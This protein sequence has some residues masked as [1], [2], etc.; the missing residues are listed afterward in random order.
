[1]N[2]GSTGSR[3][4]IFGGTFDPIHHAHLVVARTA[5]D[6]FAHDRVLFVPAS[7]PPHKW[8]A[9]SASYEDRYRMV[10]LACAADPRFVPSRIEEADAKS[11]S[12]Q[13]IE[14]IKAN[15]QPG[16]E[17]YFLIGADA[18]S[19][20]A[21]WHRYGD[22]IR[23]VQFIVVTRPGHRYVVPEAARIHKLDTVDLPVSSSAI[24]EML[25]E[26]RLPAQLPLPVAQYINDKG[27]YGYRPRH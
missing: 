16:D 15:L 9:T 26:G 22:V 8:G 23:A 18:F 12:I 20:I 5:A 7:Q 10:E 2:S 14:K 24:R 19:E 21:T 13:T 17:L 4:A 6:R 3:L 27:L 25:A 11:Y 1:L